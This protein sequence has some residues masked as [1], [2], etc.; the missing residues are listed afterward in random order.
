[1][2]VYYK[3]INLLDSILFLFQIEPNPEARSELMRLMG[4]IGA[5][6]C[7]NLLKLQASL[8]AQYRQLSHENLITILKHNH[9]SNFNFESNSR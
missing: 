2:F 4:V 7:F 8:N 3:Y 5:I 6:D 9:R 1:M